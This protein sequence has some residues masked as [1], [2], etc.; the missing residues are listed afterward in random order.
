MDDDNDSTIVPRDT[1]AQSTVSTSSDD[2]SS[3]DTAVLFDMQVADEWN[4]QHKYSQ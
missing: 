2:D 1:D 3:I 4:T